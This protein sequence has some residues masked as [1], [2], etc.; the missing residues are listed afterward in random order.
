MNA[1]VKCWVKHLLV[2]AELMLHFHFLYLS[3]T[4]AVRLASLL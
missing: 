3:D 2:V 4:G 1:L